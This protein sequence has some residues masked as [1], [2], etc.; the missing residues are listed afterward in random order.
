MI[1]LAPKA[2][3]ASVLSEGEHRDH[4]DSVAAAQRA[5]QLH[6]E[7]SSLKR[8]VPA[9]AAIAAATLNAANPALLGGP[10]APSAH[11]A[12]AASGQV[13]PDAPVS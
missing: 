12:G 6:P 1:E 3:P 10:D 5:Q 7:Y 2:V 9:A 11:R 4:H 8:I 13:Q